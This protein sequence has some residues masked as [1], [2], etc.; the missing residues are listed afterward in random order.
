YEKVCAALTRKEIQIVECIVLGQDNRQISRTL[1]IS[2]RT[3]TNHL[4]RIYDKT[5]SS[6]KQELLEKFG[7]GLI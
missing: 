4:S 6:G 5:L 3:V 1:G 7:G 2:E